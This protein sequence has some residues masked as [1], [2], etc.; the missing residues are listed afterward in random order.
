MLNIW[1][2]KQENSMD[3]Y[4]QKARWKLYLGL[5]GVIIM[6]I[7]LFYTNYLA[8]RLAEGERGYAKI[9]AEAYQT[10]NSKD[11]EAD[12]TT[13]TNIIESNK[14]IPV[15]VLDLED[16]IIVSRNFGV[17]GEE[18]KEENQA[19]LQAELQKMINSGNEAIFLEDDGLKIYSMQSTA[20]TFL[21]YLPLLQILL[22]S[23]FAFIAYLS[24]SNARRSEQD[25]VW[26]G[27]AKETAHQLGTPISGIVAWIEHLKDT[28]SNDPDQL[29][30]LGELRSDVKRLELIADRFSKIGSA[31]TLEDVNVYDE[32]EKSK[33]YMIKR[34]S[35]RV[36]FD[37]P[38]KDQNLLAKI[39]PH[40]FE[41][42]IE[43]LIR[44]ALDAMDG[45]GEISAKVYEENDMVAIDIADTGHGIPS[46]KH[47]TVFQPGY[48]TKRRGWGLGLSLAK[49]IIEDYHKGKIFVKNSSTE[50]GTTFAIRLQK[51]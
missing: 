24:F 38:D 35:R 2:R 28:A 4:S 49:R 15:L 22:L 17:D 42:V 1:R 23:A 29:E 45:E 43:N 41:W 37:F 9:F 51:S 44:N 48:S 40:L 18:Y 47:K 46:S 36:E 39:N 30:I 31:P 16:N 19:Y 3:I 10:I 5:S 12:I 25:R 32:L 7:S 6:L 26:V 50:K 33:N 14:N 13:E 27:M 11:L 34:A 8:Q 21:K 20:L